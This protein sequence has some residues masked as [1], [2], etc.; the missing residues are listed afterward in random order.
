MKYWITKDGTEIAV[1]KMETFHIE[2]CIK[3]IEKQ[4]KNGDVFFYIGN[5]S[6]P[7]EECWVDK[8]DNTDEL[9]GWIKTFKKELA[10]RN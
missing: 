10:K 4:I 5:T 3:M 2:N 6:G 1:K 9:Q 7:A 8:I